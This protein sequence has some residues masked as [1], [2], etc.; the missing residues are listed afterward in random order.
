[1]ERSHGHVTVF[2]NSWTLSLSLERVQ[3]ETSRL[4]RAEFDRAECLFWEHVIYLDWVK[5]DTSNFANSC[6]VTSTSQ[7]M[8]I[9]RAGSGSRDLFKNCCS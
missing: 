6:S 3:L 2:L 9:K 8:S 5:V 1:M 4:T 7:S